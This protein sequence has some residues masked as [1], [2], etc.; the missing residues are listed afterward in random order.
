MSTGFE[1]RVWHD[2]CHSLAEGGA[3]GRTWTPSPV[4]TTTTITAIFLGG[5]RR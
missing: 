4:L 5:R 3:A 2:A 1:H